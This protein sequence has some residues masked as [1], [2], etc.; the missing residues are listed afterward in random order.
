[1]STQKK[2]YVFPSKRQCT[3][4]KQ[5]DTEARRGGD[6]ETGKQL[7]I[8]RRATCRWKFAVNGIPVETPPEQAEKR[9]PFAC[10][11]CDKRY[12]RQGDLTRHLNRK[13]PQ[14]GPDHAEGRT[15]TDTER[16]ST[17]DAAGHH[18]AAGDAAQVGAAAS[19]SGAD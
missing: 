4:C 15:D 16:T 17:E 8:C 10:P 19:G 18:T 13:H 11:H 3:R 6:Q 14:K 9:K 1:M 2:R 7:R 12:G 5:Y